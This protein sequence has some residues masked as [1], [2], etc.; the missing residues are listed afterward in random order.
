[1]GGDSSGSCFFQILSYAPRWSESMGGN[2][3][4]G[5]LLAGIAVAQS[6]SL[7]VMEP[8]CVVWS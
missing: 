1:M 2:P 7:C 5:C 4:R 6:V 8:G 3:F